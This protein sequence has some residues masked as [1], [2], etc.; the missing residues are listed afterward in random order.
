MAFRVAGIAPAT[1]T[2]RL[3]G[4]NRRSRNVLIRLVRMECNDQ[5]ARN[6][7]LHDGCESGAEL[8]LRTSRVLCSNGNLA[9]VTVSAEQEAGIPSW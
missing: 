8:R 5:V 1:D 3:R 9:V 4:A 2:V 7:Q 6:D